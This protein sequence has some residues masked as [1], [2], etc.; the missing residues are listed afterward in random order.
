MKIVDEI[1]LISQGTFATSSTLQSAITQIRDAI[2]TIRWPAGADGF[3][4]DPA[5]R[6]KGRGQGNGV[7]PIK[8]A[9][10]AYLKSKDWQDELRVRTTGV[11]GTGPLD[12]VLETPDGLFALEWETGNI[13]SSHRALNKMC[14]GVMRKELIGGILVL[15][16]SK[17]YPYLTDRIGNIR[18]LV[19]Y[20]PMWSS[21]AVENGYIGLIVIEQDGEKEGVPR[22]PKGTDGRALL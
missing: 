22:I 9:C 13:S 7:K 14:L 3:Y 5:S 21:L 10:M 20:L 4:L 18:E 15:P 11:A 1:T 6:G 17:L 19:P 12:A 2:A 16:S 8:E